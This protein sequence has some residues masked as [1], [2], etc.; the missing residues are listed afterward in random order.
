MLPA[1]V[2]KRPSTALFARVWPARNGHGVERR[3]RPRGPEAHGARGAVEPVTVT[4]AAT[5]TAPD[6]TPHAPMIGKSACRSRRAPAR[7]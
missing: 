1:G 5:A 4:F 3:R 6:G 7:P 2:P